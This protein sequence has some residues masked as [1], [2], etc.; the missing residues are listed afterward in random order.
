MIDHQ[1]IIRAA[2]CAPD[3]TVGIARQH[4]AIGGVAPVSRNVFIAGGEGGHLHPYLRFSR[5]IPLFDLKRYFTAIGGSE[6]E[7]GAVRGRDELCVRKTWDIC[8]QS[9]ECRE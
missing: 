4:R 5:G 8:A 9:D 6:A 3:S 1:K 7:I 2:Q